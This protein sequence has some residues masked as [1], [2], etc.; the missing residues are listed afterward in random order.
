MHS[1][2]V[3]AA[4]LRKAGLPEM[5]DRAASGWYHDFLSPLDT[6]TLA[7]L[8]DLATAGTTPAKAL[9]QRVIDG[10]FDATQQESDE[11]ADS[12]EGRET[13]KRLLR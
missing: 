8:A 7:L 1:K 5:A 11:W 3:L 13:F 4:E 6:P 12:P 10:E 2:D 9:R